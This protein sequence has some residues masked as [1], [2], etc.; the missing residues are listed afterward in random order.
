MAQLLLRGMVVEVYYSVP[1]KSGKPRDESTYVTYADMDGGL[2]RIKFPGRLP[3]QPGQLV[4]GTASVTGR[5][6]GNSLILV[7]VSHSFEKRG[8]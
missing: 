2:L 7:A 4:E 1:N 5:L 6:Y 8:D 3:V